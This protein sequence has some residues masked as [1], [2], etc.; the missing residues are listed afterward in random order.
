MI[1]L[2]SGTPGSGKS[3]HCAKTIY[4]NNK[5]GLPTICNFNINRTVLKGNGEVLSLTDNILTPDYLR[6]YSNYYFSNHKFK[7]GSILLII[8]EAQIMFNSRNWN[9]YGRDNWIRFFSNHR[10]YGYDVI[11]VAQFDRMLDRQIRS[12]LEYETIHRKVS[13]F[14]FKGQVLGALCLG[15]LFVSVAIWYPMKEKVN[16]HFFRYSKKFGNLYDSYEKL[17]CIEFSEKFSFDKVENKNKVANEVYENEIVTVEEG[18]VGSL[19]DTV[20]IKS[21]TNRIFK[22][23]KKISSYLTK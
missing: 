18:A 20:T 12:L 21:L 19:S 7:E 17:D 3:L 6:A 4:I 2:Y 14:G 15:N 5:K 16:A 23:L 11:L 1:Y 9:A 13:N 10:H 22:K 8:D